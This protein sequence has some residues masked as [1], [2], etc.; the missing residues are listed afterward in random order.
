MIEL[1]HLTK[2][3][4]D[5]VAVDDLSLR[6]ETGEFFGLLGPNGAGKTTTISM[7]STVLLPTAGEI[8]IDGQKLDKSKC[9]MIGNDIHTDIG[10]A[11]A[12]GLSTFYMHTNLTPPDQPPA[13]PK[14]HPEVWAGPHWEWEGYDWAKISDVLGKICG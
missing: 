8:S 12:A 6:I 5:F 13:D 1:K 2:R 11:K 4:G 9:L 14:K 7:M 10:G 3:F